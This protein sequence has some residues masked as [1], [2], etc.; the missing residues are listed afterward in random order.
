MI[1]TLKYGN[2]RYRD[3]D[4]GNIVLVVARTKTNPENNGTLPLTDRVIE[5]FR[6]RG[7]V[8]E[9]IDIDG[10][11][12]EDDPDLRDIAVAQTMAR[13]AGEGRLWRTRYGSRTTYTYGLLEWAEDGREADRGF[14]PEFLTDELRN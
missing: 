13:L 5:A 14:K 12:R 8:G 1:Y 3:L 7:Q 9:P 4:D 11:I 2:A 6:R 10:L